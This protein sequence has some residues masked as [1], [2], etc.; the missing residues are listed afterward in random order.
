MPQSTHMKVRTKGVRE[1]QS[2]DSVKEGAHLRNATETSRLLEEQAW[3]RAFPGLGAL[4]V[5]VQVRGAE[6]RLRAGR[7]PG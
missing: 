7:D 3:W 4:S 6:G 1:T 5:R 2:G